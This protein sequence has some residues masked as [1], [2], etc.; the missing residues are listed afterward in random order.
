[1]SGIDDR[2]K[3]M[4]AKLHHDDE[5]RFKVNNRCHKLLGLWAATKLGIGGEAADEY[6]KTVV[7]SDF[8]EP[9]EEDVVRKVLADFESKGQPI[10]AQEIRDEI[11]RLRPEA[12]A[13]IVDSA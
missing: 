7:V 11:E 10:T 2:K 3:G 9:G 12:Y 5:L 1:M 8:E 6:A 13:Q 4:D